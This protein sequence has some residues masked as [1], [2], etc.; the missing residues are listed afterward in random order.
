M[1]VKGLQLARNAVPINRYYCGEQN[2]KLIRLV[3]K[4]P[5]EAR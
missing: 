4:K 5:C 3:E 2:D 1:V